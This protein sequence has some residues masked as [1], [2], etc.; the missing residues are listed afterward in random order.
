MGKQEHPLG[1]CDAA[2]FHVMLLLPGA[3]QRGG[4]SG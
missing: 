2:D 1:L 3:P 4:Q